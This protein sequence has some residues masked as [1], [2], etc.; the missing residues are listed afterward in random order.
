M[1][2]RISSIVGMLYLITSISV[3]AA[4]PTA[5]VIDGKISGQELCW[6]ELCGFAL[7]FGTF[8]G[9]VNGEHTTGTFTAIVNHS[10]LPSQPGDTPA[11]VSGSWTLRTQQ[12]D[13]AGTT[14]GT[15]TARKN[16][17]FDVNLSLQITTSTVSFSN[18]TLTFNGVLDHSGLDKQPI[19]ELPTIMGDLFQ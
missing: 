1:T 5:S 2:R 9:K 4:P 18:N 10:A 12:G 15:L 11:Q 17:R 3:A 14:T 7:F 16:D 19:P 13:F 6:Q 8:N